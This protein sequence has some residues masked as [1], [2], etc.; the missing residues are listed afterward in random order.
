MLRLGVIMYADGL[1]EISGAFSRLLDARASNSVKTESTSIQIPQF[2]RTSALRFRALLTK[3]VD[4]RTD[5]GRRRLSLAP[6][7]MR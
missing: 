5:V 2:H 1:I 6:L 3:G 7:F 4:V